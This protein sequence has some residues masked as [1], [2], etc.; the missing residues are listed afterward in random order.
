[1]AVTRLPDKATEPR[2]RPRRRAPARRSYHHGDLRA[3]LLAAAE[4]ELAANGVES[5]TLRGCARRAGVSHAA[6]AHHFPDVRLLTEMAIMGFQE[7]APEDVRL[8]P[9]EYLS[10]G[11]SNRH[12]WSPLCMMMSRT[13]AQRTTCEITCCERRCFSQ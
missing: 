5:F 12:L 7:H 2:G 1:M 9:N 11:N 8:A 10:N 3:A 6:P 4:R 13:T